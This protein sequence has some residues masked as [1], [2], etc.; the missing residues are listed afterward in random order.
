MATQS[1]ARLKGDDYQHLVSWYHIISMLRPKYKVKKVRLED[2]SAGLVDDVTIIKGDTPEH[3]DFYQIKY[4]VDQRESY[5]I[6]RLLDSS[7][8]TSLMEK[9]W[10]TWKK[11]TLLYPKENIKLILY[12]NWLIDPGDEILLCISGENGCLGDSF[13]SASANT[14]IGKK[15][16]EWR[17]SH[18]VSEEE[19]Y[20]F[21][22]SLEFHLGKDFSEGLKQQISERMELIGLKHDEGS[23]H[24]AAGIVRDWIK[25]KVEEITPG[26]LEEKIQQFDLYLP[27][28]SE[29]SAAV[30]FVT[31]KDRKFDLTPDYVLDWKAY[32]KT[33][34]DRGDHELY[35]N[36]DWNKNLLPELLQLESRINEEVQ[37]NL[38]RVRGFSRL[39]AW[40]AFGHTF[41][42]V[43][44]YVLEVNQ[45]NNLWRTDMQGN[46][47]FELVSENVSGT[48]LSKDNRTV[49][50]GI[51][52]TGS[53]REDVVKYISE[54]SS[55]DALLLLSPKN[56]VAKDAFR[57][58]G[59][60]VAFVNQAKI[61]IR[62]FVKTNN[63]D[64]LMVFYFGPLSGACFLG[65]QLNATCKEI[66]IMENTLSQSYIPSFLLRN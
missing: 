23:L 29:K 51:S 2:P 56:G 15:R 4:H 52:I 54:N 48:F 63:A 8:G 66:Q 46:T 16:E 20:S 62:E 32:F 61:K 14:N 33:V 21:T 53:L 37:A 45:Q 47:D 65:H 44:G 59:D 9:F 30:Y 31:I 12:S 7:S 38:I 40:F 10:K 3:V 60:V 6:G 27:S 13:Y 36:E 43:G 5:S 57:D 39:S 1:S 25:A 11:V 19:F 42:E 58:G 26:L 17:K 22:R 34:S 18:A 28:G 24:I 35:N 55:V 50:V 64:K 41:S 49:A